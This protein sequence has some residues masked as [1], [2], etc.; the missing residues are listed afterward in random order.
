VVAHLTAQRTR[1]D[2]TARKTV[3]LRLLKGLYSRG[4]D[5]V[6]AREWAKYID[7]LLELPAVVNQQVWQE[8][9]A[10]EKEKQMPFVTSFEKIGYERGLNEGLKEGRCEGLY[11]AIELGL[12]LK[13]AAEGLAL[14][15]E[16]RQKHDLVLLDAL[17]EAIKSAGSV[18]DIRR[19]LS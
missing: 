14:M 4:M 1:D 6:D 10:I 3:K 5:A 9:H 2:V 13:F 19:L 18:D 17:Y 15:P 11:K 8:V 16:V 7:W 12:Q